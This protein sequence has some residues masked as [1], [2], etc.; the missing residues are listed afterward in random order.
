MSP[1]C[2]RWRRYNRP[3]A[4]TLEDALRGLDEAF[5]MAKSIRVEFDDVY[6]RLIAIVEAM[7]RNQAGADKSYVWEADQAFRDHF[8]RVR[9]A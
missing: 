1:N 7:P 2:R 3:V 9:R 8:K 6:R 5:E 4:H